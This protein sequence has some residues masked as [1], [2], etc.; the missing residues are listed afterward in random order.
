MPR[1]HPP[2]RATAHVAASAALCLAALAACVRP[3]PAQ[4]PAAPRPAMTREAAGRAGDT[5]LASTRV[6]AAVDAAYARF[7]GLR[8]GKNADYIPALAA[9]DPALFGIAVVT[10]DGR[11]FIAGDAATEVSIQSISKVFTMAAVS[12]ATG[13]ESSVSCLLYTSDAADDN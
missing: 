9:V 6:Q 1:H 13:A 5:L 4:R 2:P 3:L 11:L 7:K 8:E 12:E 10:A